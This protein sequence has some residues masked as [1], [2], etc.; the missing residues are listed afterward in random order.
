MLSPGAKPAETPRQVIITLEIGN[1][2]CQ[3]RQR[4]RCALEGAAAILAFGQRGPERPGSGQRRHRCRLQ[5]YGF[6]ENADTV[7]RGGNYNPRRDVRMISS[8]L[9]RT[10]S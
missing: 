5:G 4:L 9:P 8:R 10:G 1:R 7:C 6:C 2:L 3:Q